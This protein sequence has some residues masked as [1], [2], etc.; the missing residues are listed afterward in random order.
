MFN[1]DT[2]FSKYDYEVIMDE[3]LKTY[4]V[5][6]DDDHIKRHKVELKKKIEEVTR[7]LKESDL[8]RDLPVLDNDFSSYVICN[9]PINLNFI[10]YW[11]NFYK[12]KI[13]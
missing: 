9:F 3:I 7:K 12:S 1:I 11:L 5:E 10:V 8:L 13:I 2:Y 6:K 4:K